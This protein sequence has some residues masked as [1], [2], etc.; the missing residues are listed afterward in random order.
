[1]HPESSTNTRL[2]AEGSSLWIE[3]LKRHEILQQLLEGAKAKSHWSLNVSRDFLPQLSP[4]SSEGR[5]SAGVEAETQKQGNT[6]G[7]SISPFK[8]LQSPAAD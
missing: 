1:M 6:D 8:G 2:Q 5:R 3:A 7:F 4:V